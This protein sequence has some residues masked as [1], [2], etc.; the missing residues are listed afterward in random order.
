MKIEQKRNIVL[1]SGSP[2]RKEYLERYGLAFVVKTADVNESFFPQ[3]KPQSFA[4]RMAE[5]K[6]EAVKN[7]CDKTDILI[8]ADTIV[9]YNDKILGKPESASEVLPMLQELNGQEH[10]VLTSYI[11]WDCRSEKKI[12][13][14]VQTSA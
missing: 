6:A 5:E 8:A 1:A 2:R 11:V 13:R 4:V 10:R 12:I 9:V 3:E 7:L 14:T